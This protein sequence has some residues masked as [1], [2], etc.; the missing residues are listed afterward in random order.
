[1]QEEA[2][3]NHI[4]AKIID[5][6][7]VRPGPHAAVSLVHFVYLICTICC[8]AA[9]SKNYFLCNFFYLFAFLLCDKVCYHSAVCLVHVMCTICCSF[10]VGF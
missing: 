3:V 2:G 6:I 8:K 10:H 7:S 1:M 5:V 9:S 4:A